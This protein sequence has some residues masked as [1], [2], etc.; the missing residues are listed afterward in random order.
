M[1]L[2]RTCPKK[3]ALAAV[4]GVLLALAVLPGCNKAAK[5]VA[6]ALPKP[7]PVAKTTGGTGTNLPAEFVSVFDDSPPPG[8]TGRDPFNPDSTL[9]NPAAVGPKITATTVVAAPLL[10]LYS[11]TGSPGRWMVVINNQIIDSTEINKPIPVRV[12]GGIVTVR[13]VEIGED[14]ANVTVDGSLATKRLTMGQKK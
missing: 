11:V 10:R 13:V 7:A 5:P 6:A 4:A 8:N 2:L 1:K 9:R 14:Y 12:P 3:A